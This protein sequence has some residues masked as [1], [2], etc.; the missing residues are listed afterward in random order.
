MRVYMSLYFR[1][2]HPTYISRVLLKYSG[3][4]RKHVPYIGGAYIFPFSI[5]KIQSGIRIKDRGS[6]LF[7]F[8]KKF[9]KIFPGVY[10]PLYFFG[11]ISGEIYPTLVFEIPGIDFIFSLVF[12]NYL[13]HSRILQNN[14]KPLISISVHLALTHRN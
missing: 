3:N 10:T 7:Y 6:G 2:I 4:I 5:S 14:I 13:L 11:F 8:S 12:F 1:H 9:P